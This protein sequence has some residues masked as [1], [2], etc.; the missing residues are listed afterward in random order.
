[1]IKI[2]STR[3]QDL[4]IIKKIY[5]FTQKY[6][7]YPFP[8]ELKKILGMNSNLLYNHMI[9]LKRDGLMERKRKSV[10]GNWVFTP[11]ALDYIEKHLQ[12]EVEND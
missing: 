9:I 6:G 2:L 8:G 7:R 1:M 10:R 11:A 3:P 12:K 4:V 5:A